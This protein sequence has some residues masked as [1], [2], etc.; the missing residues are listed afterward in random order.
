MNTET[1]KG[2]T[3]TIEETESNQFRLL[4]QSEDALRN[5]Y[6]DLDLDELIGIEIMI[7]E[8]IDAREGNPRKDALQIE[9]REDLKSLIK[10][11]VAQVMFERD[12]TRPHNPPYPYQAPPVYPPYHY[13]YPQSPYYTI[14]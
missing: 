6:V 12:Q 3:I 5:G 14:T 10:E 7:G 13:P 2:A 9:S 1:K 11:A 4:L 8:V